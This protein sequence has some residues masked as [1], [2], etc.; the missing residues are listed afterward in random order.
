MR[1]TEFVIEPGRQDV[2]MRRVFDA[3]REAV[4]EVVTDPALIPRWYG[5]PSITVEVERM[6][7]RPGGRWR[8][9][10]RDAHG[11]EVPFSGVY[12]DVVA[13]ERIV[14]T[15]EWEGPGEVSLETYTLE[16]LGG[17]T[18]Y[19]AQS[20]FRSLTA[21]DAMIRGGAEAGGTQSMDRLA[22]LLTEVL[23][24]RPTGH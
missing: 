10:N 12:H 20:V 13:P 9:V 24:E 16:D 1:A 23:A 6:E 17:R 18:R 19:V 21:R 15:F 8:Y 5:P 22:D 4:F 11:N 3:P 14:R 2:V 7:V